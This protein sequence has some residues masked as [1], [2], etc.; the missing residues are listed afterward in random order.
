MRIA[1][2]EIVERAVDISEGRV[3]SLD[4]M[5]ATGMWVRSYLPIHE[6]GTNQ[7]VRVM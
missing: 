6:I 7:Q 2:A 3:V 5:T 4:V 1:I